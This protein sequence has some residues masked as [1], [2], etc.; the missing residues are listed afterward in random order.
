[1]E[2]FLANRVFVLLAFVQV[3]ANVDVARATSIQID[4]G[5]PPFLSTSF[6]VP[7]TDLN[8]TALSG[9]DL[10]LDLVFSG[11]QFVRLF[12]VTTDF[13]ISLKL[14]SN[15]PGSPGF[16]SGTGFLS[17]QLGN[18]L[19]P[20][21]VLGSASSSDGS[22]LILLLPLL[23]GSGAPDRPFDFFDVHFDLTLPSN[24]PFEITGG[25]FALDSV[26]GGP[27]GVGPGVPRDIVPDPGNTLIFL[28]LAFS[29]IILSHFRLERVS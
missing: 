15:T 16:P 1:M 17:D 7:F 25:E 28:S 6:A 18:P 22:M 26:S 3:L 11:T 21:Q 27:F 12:S 8:G 23:P 10:S 4:L 13:Q 14:E 2:R 19:L 9:Q 29:L 5:S 24:S 20:A